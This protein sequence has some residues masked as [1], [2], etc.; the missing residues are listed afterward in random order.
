MPAVRS[1]A[2]IATKW[3]DR[4]ATA[5]PYYE[6]G[7]TAPLKDW[8]TGAK[9]GQ[10]AYDA[11]MA[12]PKTRALRTKG[13]DRV[14]SEKWSR[15][16]KAVGPAR[17]REGVG[18]AEPD[19]SSGFGPY[20]DEIERITLPARGPRGDPKNLDRVKAIMTALHKKRIGA[21]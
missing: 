8:A 4:A 9:A 1:I 5:A 17:F 13:I 6:S 7:V 12:D 15:K 11:A 20:R 10:K 2:D 21:S 18:V 14:G 16:A 3:A 19:Y